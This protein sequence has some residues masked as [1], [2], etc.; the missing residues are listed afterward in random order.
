MS[1]GER[2]QPAGELSRLEEQIGRVLRLGV[3]LSATTLGAGLVLAFI[4]AAVA[5]LLLS[6]GLAVLMAIPVTRIAASFVD[7]VRRHDGL[8]SWSTAVVLS[9]M[10]LTLVY[11]LQSREADAA[12]EV[13]H[14]FSVDLSLSPDGKR[15]VYVATAD[16]HDQLFVVEVGGSKPARLLA[17]QANDDDPAWSPDGK[18]IAFVS[19]ATGHLEIYVANADGSG[20]RQ[21]T[22]DGSSAIH[23]SWSADA[24]RIAYCVQ[25]N[26][27]GQP[28]RF[29]LTEIG[30][31]GNGRRQI[32]NDGG[33]ATYPSWSPDG[34]RLAFRKVVGANS[35]VFTV[36][37]DGTDERNV[38]NDTAFDG[39]P[40]WSPDG[41]YIAFA[42]DRRSNFQIFVVKPD[43]GP[44]QLVANTTGR[45]TSPRWSPDSKS[46][47][48]TN[49]T[50][51]GT[52]PDCRILKAELAK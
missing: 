47:Y 1:G 35:E 52:Q 21:L 48:F 6:V 43:G 13:T 38:T 44:A 17:S 26:A 15:M 9:V 19:D 34:S 49:C 2:P 28:E 10:A 24:A 14:G 33:V 18:E 29:E 7:A 30:R 46:I 27:A 50:V 20:V 39:W 42:S 41:R 3:A 31:D 22:H 36:K 25:L 51:S 11:S 5:P 45:A 8:L 12:E 16:G 37:A 23:P 32:T 4:G 40:A